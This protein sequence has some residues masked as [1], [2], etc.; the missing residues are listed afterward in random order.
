MSKNK[1]IYRDS[2]RV[3]R[4]NI[5]RCVASIFFLASCYAL[6]YLIE[7]V[8]FSA[9]Y[10][11][12]YEGL[13]FN[14]A[15]TWSLFAIIVFIVL[16]PLELGIKKWFYDIAR[17]KDNDITQMFYYFTS[18][19]IFVKAVFIKLNLA[20]R[21][22]AIYSLVIIPCTAIWILVNYPV[23]R[24]G[25]SVDGTYLFVIAMMMISIILGGICAIYFS[26]KYFLV[27][28]IFFNN[29]ETSIN[30][31][32]KKSKEI[33]TGKK[34][35]VFTLYFTILPICLLSVFILPLIV[36]VP[37]MYILT[38]IKAKQLMAKLD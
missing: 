34:S 16:S 21:L 23:T 3:I 24:H 19:K 14:T 17:L 11:N 4:D 31:C 1:H 12:F 35:E 28:Y 6:F 9:S 2:V 20:L 22:I 8:I 18:A 26:Y 13:G 25:V 29:G 36:I 15:I 27:Y 37:Y 38:S 30:N 32:V 10:Q 33:M 7:K 5:G